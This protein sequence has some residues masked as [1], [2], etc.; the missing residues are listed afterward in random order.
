M[1]KQELLKEIETN[2][3][4]EELAKEIAEIDR[5]VLLN[6]KYLSDTDWYYARHIETSEEIPTDISNSRAE[7]REYIRSQ[8]DA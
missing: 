3:F 4:N 2:G 1:N 6:R 5:Q 7:A 8:E